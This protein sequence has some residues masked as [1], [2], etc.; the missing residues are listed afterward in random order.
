MRT[1]RRLRDDRVP[2]PSA[3]LA[4]PKQKRASYV[5]RLTGMAAADEPPFTLDYWRLNIDAR[6]P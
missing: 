3:A 4:F 6:K 5:E 1:V 2:A